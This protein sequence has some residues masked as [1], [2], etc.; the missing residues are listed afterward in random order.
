MGYVS[1][2]G[3]EEQQRSAMAGA[4]PVDFDPEDP[5][6][7]KVHYD[8][9]GWDVDQ[10]G[11]LSA[12]LAERELVH[13]WD[14]DEVIVPESLEDQVDAVFDELE[15]RLGPFA[16]VLDDDAEAVRFDLD[17]LDAV[18]RELVRTAIVEAQVPHRWEMNVLAVDTE[19]ADEVDDLLDAIERGDIA[20]FDDDGSLDGVLGELYS[21][22]DRLRRDPLDTTARRRVLDYAAELDARRAPFGVA[23]GSWARIVGATSAL[24][25]AFGASDGGDIADGG[26]MSEFDPQRIAE[27]AA[28]LHSVTRPFV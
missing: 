28:E 18:D 9:R 5:D 3:E 12:V 25:A 21:A 19:A 11:E 7:V 20:T 17:D 16:V 26:D 22:G 2:S 1:R 10:R 14:G 13:I 4:P 23:L 24:A 27:A 8:V 6:V 15:E